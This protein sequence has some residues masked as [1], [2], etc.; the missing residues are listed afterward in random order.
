MA[1]LALSQPDWDLVFD[2]NEDLTFNDG[3]EETNQNS[4]FR[5][6]V[7]L[8][9]MFD[10][11]RKG[12]PWFTDMVDPR[13]DVDT[14]K[15]IIRRAILSTPGVASLDTL[16]LGFDAETGEMAVNFSGTTTD[17]DTFGSSA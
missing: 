11:T 16:E 7:L 13:V 15:Q 9:E 6:Q 3:A 10:D 8:G 17:G 4:K 2:E 12:I 5:L 1:D 14:K